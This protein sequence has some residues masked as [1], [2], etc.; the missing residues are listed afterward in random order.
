MR[1]TKR[2]K[3]FALAREQARFQQG[4][5]HG[6]VLCR[7]RRRIRP[8]CARCGRARAR[9]PRARRSGSRSC[10]ARAG[11]AGAGSRTR[12]STSE[13][14]KSCAAA[15]AADGDKRHVRGMPCSAQ[16]S[17]Q[18]PV[19]HARD[20]RRSSSAGR[21]A[22]RK[23]LRATGRAGSEPLLPLA[24]SRLLEA[25][26]PPWAGYRSWAIRR[27]APGLRRGDAGRQGEHLVAGLGDQHRVLPL[28][29]Q[30]VV[31]GHDGPAVGE[32]RGCPACRR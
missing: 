14:G 13:Q 1:L 30:A 20:C 2:R 12:T 22:A 26:V 21:R 10:A 11:S 5:L 3:Q 16:R 7:D 32:L 6:D 18:Q 23:A 15:V 19:H 17:L 8:R 4:G 29:R 27:P 25:R 24:N 28:R 31:L 9:C